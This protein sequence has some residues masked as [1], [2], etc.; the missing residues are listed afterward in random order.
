MV[1][2]LKNLAVIRYDSIGGLDSAQR[3]F[4]RVASIDSPF[5]EQ[6]AWAFLTTVAR[7]GMPERDLDLWAEEIVED[8]AKAA[9]T[10]PSETPE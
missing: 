3:N 8:A 7:P 9:G 6:V 1:A 5:R 2:N 10:T 4:E